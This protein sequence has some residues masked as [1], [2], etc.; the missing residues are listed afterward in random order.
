MR[1]VMEGVV[2]TF[3]R[4]VGRLAPVAA[5]LLALALQG[6]STSLVTTAQGPAEAADLRRQIMM[7][8]Q[9]LRYSQDVATALADTVLGWH[10]GAA[11]MLLGCKASVEQADP[12]ARPRVERQVAE[13]IACRIRDEIT[14]DREVFDLADVVARRHANCVGYAQL[15][16]VVGRSAGLSI[17]P[18][19]V[20]E[21]QEPGPLLEGARHVCCLVALSDGAAIMVNFAPAFISLPFAL[22]EAYGKSGCYLRLNDPANPPHLYR[23]IQVLGEKGLVAHLYNSRGV[24]LAAQ[25]RFAAALELYAKAVELNPELAEAWNNRGVALRNGGDLDEALSSYDRA[26]ELDANHAEA[27]INRGSARARAGQFTEAFRDYDRAAQLNPRSAAVHNN[28][29]TAYHRQGRL[30][31]AIRQYTLAIELDPGLA[32]AYY[33]RGNAYGKLGEHKQAVR[34]Y[35]RAIQRNPRMEQAYINRGLS[36][37]EL[38]QY[39]AAKRDLL[40][41][42]TISPTPATREYIGRISERVG[43]DLQVAL[44]NG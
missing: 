14:P 17:E 36:H 41:A 23:R 30:S 5:W 10:S 38:R 32:E 21:A 1:K 20:L 16:Y 12:Q 8:T 37:A 24:A 28:L 26:I 13:R 39:E 15:F 3:L 22:D 18:I 6:C 19:G 27:F 11:P 34:D 31:E 40:Q 44:G 43:L 25:G 4:H 9:S 42:L 29:A 33:N 2:R 7:Q 35:T